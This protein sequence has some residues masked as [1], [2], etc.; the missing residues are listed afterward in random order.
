M[1]RELPL[2]ERLPW[3]VRF[4]AERLRAGKRGGNFLLRNMRSAGMLDKCIALPIN[5]RE[6]VLVPLYWM[7]VWLSDSLETYEQDAVTKFSAAVAAMGAPS[8]MVDCGA[9]VGIFSR[10]VL[11]RTPNVVRLIAFEPNERSYSLLKR[12]TSG[13]AIQTDI[14]CGGVLDEPGQGTLNAEPYKS[15]GGFVQ[16]SDTGGTKLYTVDQMGIAPDHGLAMKI[17]VE[18]GELAVLR[19]AAKTIRAARRIVVQFEAHPEVTERTGVDAVECLKLLASLRDCS[20]FV[21]ERPEAKITLDKPFFEQT[22]ADSNC[23][24]IVVS[25]R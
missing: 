23:N 20:W 6:S 12:N 5:S 8:V 13:L 4:A 25:P 21:A 1:Q 14:L 24:V 17:D 10:A 16:H 9:D 19:G 18:G 7:Y 11:A 3:H 2:V 22:H 15:H